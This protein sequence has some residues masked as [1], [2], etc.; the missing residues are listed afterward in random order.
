MTA[1]NVFH[2]VRVKKETNLKKHHKETTWNKQRN[3][4]ENRQRLTADTLSGAVR[5]YLL[6]RCAQL[7]YRSF[8]DFLPHVRSL[9]EHWAAARV[10]AGCSTK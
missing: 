1:E 2:L 7:A 8:E 5:R 4:K 3:N 10:R 6:R 9:A